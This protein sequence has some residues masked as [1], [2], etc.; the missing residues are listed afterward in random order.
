MKGIAVVV[1]LLTVFTSAS[2]A[3]QTQCVCGIPNRQ[4]RSTNSSPE[5]P[6]FF[7]WTVFIAFYADGR[8]KKCTGALIHQSYILTAAHCTPQSENPKALL[9]SFRQECGTKNLTDDQLLPIRRIARHPGYAKCDGTGPC[10]TEGSDIAIL[11][12][13]TPQ[14]RIMPICLGDS[15]D[16]NDLIVSGWG[17]INDDYENDCQRVAT[18][19][20]VTDDKCH[21]FNPTTPINLVMC[22]GSKDTSNICYGDSGS[23]LMTYEDDRWYQVGVSS[24]G[25]DN[26]ATT[27]EPSGFERISAHVPWIRRMTNNAVCINPNSRWPTESQARFTSENPQSPAQPGSPRQGVLLNPQTAGKADPASTTLPEPG[28]AGTTGISQTS[29]RGRLRRKCPQNQHNSLISLLM[30]QQSLIV[31]L[32]KKLDQMTGKKNTIP[33]NLSGLLF[34]FPDCFN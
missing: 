16:Y 17:R 30:H 25:K 31:Q 32:L 6:Y 7:P 28:A 8:R 5:K 33:A 29:S 26:C 20:M 18:L 11:E 24:F 27:R 1:V 21:K 10:T 23:A 34:E 15:G 2:A 22:A 3:G 19:K 12:L 4:V 9:V 13:V 14:P